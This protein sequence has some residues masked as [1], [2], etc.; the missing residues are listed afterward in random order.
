MRFS[1]SEFGVI[2]GYI[3]FDNH[4]G[5]EQPYL[6]TEEINIDYMQFIQPARISEEDFKSVW[7]RITSGEVVHEQNIQANS[8]M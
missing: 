3:N 5:L 2:Y 6:I 4:A 8:N 7:Q 1:G